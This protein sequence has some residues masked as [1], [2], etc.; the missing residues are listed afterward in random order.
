MNA[1]NMAADAGITMKR[2]VCTK[3]KATPE[4]IKAANMNKN[5]TTSGMREDTEIT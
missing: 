3:P 4:A 2:I 1:Q 5:T